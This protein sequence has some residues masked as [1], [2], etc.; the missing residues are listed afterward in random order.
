MTEFLGVSHIM[1]ARYP[2]QSNPRT[3]RSTPERCTRVH[4]GVLKKKKK[5]GMTATRPG[6]LR[7][8]GLQPRRSNSKIEEPVLSS[9]S[10]KHL[11]LNFGGQAK[12]K[13]VLVV[14]Y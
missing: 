6:K 10:E 11:V 2:R 5:K 8:F 3:C 14:D 1:P 13:L 7:D 4:Y 12:C 9:R